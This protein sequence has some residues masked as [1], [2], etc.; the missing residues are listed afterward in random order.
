MNTPNIYTAYT[1]FYS[2]Y[3]YAAPYQSS[4]LWTDPYGRSPLYGRVHYPYAPGSEQQFPCYHHWAQPQLPPNYRYTGHEF[5]YHL[6]EPPALFVPPAASTPLLPARGRSRLANP[7][8]IAGA[9]KLRTKSV[10]RPCSQ[11]QSFSCE[12]EKRHRSRSQERAHMRV[13]V[14]PEPIASTPPTREDSVHVEESV[15]NPLPPIRTPLQNTLSPTT[16]ISS[17]RED[18]PST[19]ED[20]ARSLP[21][22]ASE[23]VVV[24]RGDSSASASPTSP[25]TSLNKYGGAFR[26]VDA[27]RTPPSLPLYS[28][29]LIEV[30]LARTPPTL[31]LT[32]AST[33]SYV[34]G[35]LILTPID[36]PLT[37]GTEIGTPW[38]RGG[39]HTRLPGP[40][41]PYP[42][43]TVL[44]T[45]SLSQEG[46]K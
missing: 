36:N 10:P 17:H 39:S 11:P 37:P 18:V 24:I 28:P 6:P 30:A 27:V 7:P 4:P 19:V 13:I 41:T 46:R 15:D 1:G 42:R 29:S 23:P 32:P 22:Q 3:N 25:F 31:Q 5:V 35:P 21:S 33:V 20:V 16:S 12:V 9:I 26:I 40:P 34:H 2:G 14:S 43:G 44:S 45:D 38:R 8:Q